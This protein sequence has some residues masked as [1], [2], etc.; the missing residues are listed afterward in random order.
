MECNDRWTRARRW[1]EIQLADK[2]VSLNRLPSYRRIGIDTYRRLRC[3]WPFFSSN[4]CI[5]RY[6][7]SIVNNEWFGAW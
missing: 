7:G 1:R 6:L 2:A 3:T 5:E 4:T